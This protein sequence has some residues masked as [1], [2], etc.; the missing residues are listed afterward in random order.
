VGA[1]DTYTGTSLSMPGPNLVTPPASD[2]VPPQGRRWFL[3]GGKTGVRVWLPPGVT[4]TATVT[5]DAIPPGYVAR[6]KGMR[7]TRGSDDV[8]LNTANEPI[9][10]IPLDDCAAAHGAPLGVIWWPTD[11]PPLGSRTAPIPG[12]FTAGYVAFGVPLERGGSIDAFATDLWADSEFFCG[13]CPAGSFCSRATCS[14]RRFEFE[15]GRLGLSSI[16]GSIFQG[17]FYF[18]GEPATGIGVINKVDLSGVPLAV[19]TL[20]ADMVGTLGG[21]VA[22]ETGLY[23]VANVPADGGNPAWSGVVRRTPDGQVVRLILDSNN[24]A[25]EAHDVRGRPAVRNGRIFWSDEF[26]I[27]AASVD[28]TTVATVLTNDPGGARLVGVGD[29]ELL[30]WSYGGS[31]LKRLRFADGSVSS[32][33]TGGVFDKADLS[34]GVAYWIEGARSV[35]RLAPGG[36]PETV[37][38]SESDVDDLMAE[39]EG[40]YLSI[41]LVK[42]RIVAIPVGASAPTNIA[43]PGG[44]L[45]GV[46]AT[47]L[48]FWDGASLSGVPRLPM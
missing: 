6:S 27:R 7:L 10:Q 44:I 17:S 8:G 21:V 4:M 28:S 14:G 29:D 33:V 5:G 2:M 32:L 24:P 12:W 45:L 42:G 34:S 15:P 9:V 22:N 26:S 35:M 38:V 43:A 48:Y 31:T 16:R 25:V 3:V 37:Y 13:V 18:A 47:T 1:S 46:D 19:T 40:V 11:A 23:W 20:V 41:G 39:P 36:D 30:Y